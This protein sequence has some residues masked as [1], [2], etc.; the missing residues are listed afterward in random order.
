MNDALNTFYWQGESGNVIWRWKTVGDPS[1]A[2]KSLNHQWWIPKKSEFEIV[3][4]PDSIN[5]QEVKD[6]IWEDMQESLN[7][8]KELY[9]LHKAN[10]V[11]E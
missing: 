1:P 2:Y 10:K 7:Y 6:A 3:S 4:A 11:K 9:K 5:K 8:F